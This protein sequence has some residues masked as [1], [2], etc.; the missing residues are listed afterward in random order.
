MFD[1]T[2][3]ESIAFLTNVYKN[4]S[5]NSTV[6]GSNTAFQ[7]T[8]VLNDFFKAYPDAKEAPTDELSARLAKYVLK[9]RKKSIHLPNHL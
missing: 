7:M 1:L 3:P 2:A 4:F 6:L 9:D 5:D 8:S